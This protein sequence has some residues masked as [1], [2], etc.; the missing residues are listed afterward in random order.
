[1]I[2]KSLDIDIESGLIDYIDED[3]VAQGPNA[4]IDY[5]GLGIEQEVNVLLGPISMAEFASKVDHYTDLFTEIKEKSLLPSGLNPD[6]GLF[7]DFL[8]NPKFIDLLRVSPEDLDLTLDNLDLKEA[9]LKQFNINNI[10]EFYICASDLGSSAINFRSTQLVYYI[11]KCLFDELAP[12]DILPICYVFSLIEDFIDSV[13][14]IDLSEYTTIPEN[15][16][17]RIPIKPSSE[18]PIIDIY[19]QYMICYIAVCYILNQFKQNQLKSNDIVE[20]QGA[21]SKTI[22]IS[23][24]LYTIITGNLMTTTYT[25]YKYSDDKFIVI[26]KFMNALSKYRYP[27]D[28]IEDGE[29]WSDSH[30]IRFI[31]K[32][33]EAKTNIFSF[34]KIIDLGGNIEFD[35]GTKYEIKTDNFLPGDDEYL[36]N[37]IGYGLNNELRSTITELDLKKED[38]VKKNTGIL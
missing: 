35:H 1:M 27:Y 4:I 7:G 21:T 24:S 14:S 16:F 30:D 34:Q 13:F 20:V 26:K 17:R 22:N 31:D 32:Y 36:L 23:G 12:S 29:S 10:N 25:H 37:L 6:S 9:I 15:H 8:K 38:T 19:I 5:W 11:L 2:M 33:K 28:H 18:L 3:I